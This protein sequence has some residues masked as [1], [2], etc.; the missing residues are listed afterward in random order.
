MFDPAV[1]HGYKD[2]NEYLYINEGND[3]KLMAGLLEIP[4]I[5]T[6]LGLPALQKQRHF[7]EN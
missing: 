7:N 5:R 1:Q 4:K 3:L 2:K 6:L